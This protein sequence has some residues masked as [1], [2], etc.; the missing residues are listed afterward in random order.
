[1]KKQDGR[2]NN[3]IH[4]KYARRIGALEAELKLLRAE[5]SERVLHTLK[6]SLHEAEKRNFERIDASFRV[7]EARL[8]IAALEKQ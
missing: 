3:G 8:I 6:A 1:M 7:N 5:Q 4:A 2:K